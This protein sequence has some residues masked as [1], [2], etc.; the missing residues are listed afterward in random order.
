MIGNRK[1]S[2][3]RGMYLMTAGLA[4]A[5]LASG[6]GGDHRISLQEFLAAEQEHAATTQ[7][8]VEPQP[9]PP[10]VIDAK[11]GPY[12]VGEDDVLLV[13]LTGLDTASVLPPITARVNHE[14]KILLP[15]VGAIE[16]QGKELED[17]ERAIL[18]AYVPKVY[19][20]VVV[21][22]GLEQARMTRVLV[23]G[24]VTTPGLVQL[25]RSERNLLFAIVGAGGVSDV[26]SGVAKL[27][28]LRNPAEEIS[29]KLTD[30][31][32]LKRALV[33]DPLQDGDVVHVVAAVPNTVFVGGLVLQ[34]RPQPYPPGVE[35]TV[36]Q[37]I[38]ASGGLRT[39]VTP[40]E[41]T[42]IRRR[43]NG[44]DIQVKLN[45]DRVTKGQDPNITLA[46]GDVLWVPDTLE[47][48]VQDWINKNIFFRAGASATY[49]LSYDSQGL[50]FLNSAAR[51]SSLQNAGD[52]QDTY[53]PFGFLLRNQSLQNLNRVPASP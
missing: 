26:A 28:R 19:Q 35:M 18:E 38:A 46:A 52:L 33:M 9:I 44:E 4:W 24:A 48:R 53:D 20:D 16:V 30:P 47:T 10:E 50:H 21:N 15:A 13:T 31:D 7:P 12:R 6:C 2:D 43:P 42:L 25:R 39:D 22:V 41:A 36:L 40:R 8:A 27:K 17:V 37:A 49:N 34:P 32:D 1:R 51:D 29:L 23:T 3:W 45:L 5:L 14:G 11:L